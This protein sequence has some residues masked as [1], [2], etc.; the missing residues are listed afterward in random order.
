MNWWGEWERI[1]RI[2]LWC[3]RINLTCLLFLLSIRIDQSMDR[4]EI[5]CREKTVYVRTWMAFWISGSEQASGTQIEFDILW[6][7][8]ASES[9]IRLWIQESLKFCAK[10]IWTFE[11]L[12]NFQSSSYRQYFPRIT[13]L[14]YVCFTCKHWSQWPKSLY[15]P[16]NKP[17]R[18][19]PHESKATFMIPQENSI[20]QLAMD[21]VRVVFQWTH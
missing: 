21:W 9:I 3:T 20:S 14:E 8:K 2:G 11:S 6:N 18:I 16:C 4:K 15:S 5:G 19:L 13:R 7:R 17:G 1:R 12:G 10:D